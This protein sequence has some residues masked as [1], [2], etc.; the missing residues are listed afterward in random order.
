MVYA[1][2]DLSI[3]QLLD[4]LITQSKRTI[5]PAMRTNSID[6]MRQLAMQGSAIGFQTLVGLDRSIAM[7]ELVHVP[8]D[9]KG[10][11][12]SDLGIYVRAGRSV[13][14]AVDLFLKILVEEIQMIEGAG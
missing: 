1:S 5:D 3:S 11:V 12:W 4:P 6:L 7:G 10:P 2:N 8:L 14:A 9:A 13:P